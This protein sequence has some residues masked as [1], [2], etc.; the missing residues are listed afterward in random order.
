MNVIGGV[1]VR[2]VVAASVSD[3]SRED[4]LA[5]VGLPATVTRA[6]AS[7]EILSA[8]TYYDLIERAT[9]PGDADLPIRYGELFD[10]DALG[11]LGL[12]FK[13]APT[14]RDALQ[15][16]S[17]YILVLTN[18]LE[19]E[20]RPAEAGAVYVLSRP[21]HRRGARIANECAMAAIVKVLR[22]ATTRALAPSQVTFSHPAPSSTSRHRDYFGAPV[23]FDASHNSL[24][25]SDRVLATPTKL[26][27]EGISAF[28]LAE[29]DQLRRRRPD[30]PLD[31]QVYTAVTDA[32]PDGLP[33]RAQ[34][35]RRL[36]MSERTMLRR[37]AEHGETYQSIARR[38]QLEAAEALVTEG[39]AS[40]GEIAFLTG[41]S[42]QSAFSRAFKG[43]TGVTPMAFREGLAG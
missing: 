42:D 43:Y 11:A 18:T 17:R 31:D 9:P 37:L 8:D 3:E 7:R 2:T 30:R 32:L 5:S 39:T 13:T 25:L 33:R 15:R 14:V 28:L 34:I 27:D 38:A 22:E 20:L 40:F 6:E 41:F 16:L 23:V 24:V 36:G 10:L 26:G 29:L 12:A 1:F 35:A 19:Y 21:D 4:L